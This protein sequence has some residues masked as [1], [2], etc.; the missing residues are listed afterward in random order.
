MADDT[1]G[2]DKDAA[3]EAPK[4]SIATVGEHVSDV[5]VTIGPKFLLLFSEQL[6]SSPNKAFEELVS[7][8]WD[9]G[10][11]A[12]YIGMAEDL[13]A[14]DAAVWV[15]DNGESMDEAGI[16]LLWKVA[17]STKPSRVVKRPQIGKFGIGKLSTYLL[18]HQLTY[19]CKASDGVI[20]AVTLD[21]R[22]I[23]K[24]GEGLHIDELPLEVRAIT[25]DE[26][27]DL[28]ADV[29]GAD[30]ILSILRRGVPHEKADDADEFG[31]G[32]GETQTADPPTGTWTLVVLTDLKDAGRAMETGR[33]RRMLRT[34]LP[35]GGAIS[36]NYC[37]EVLPSTKLDVP[38]MTEW[39]LGPGLGVEVVERTHVDGDSKFLAVTEHA[40][41]YPHLTVE[42]IEG[43]I[44]GT[45]RLFTESISGGKSSAVAASNGFFVNIV[46]RVVN[47]SD[48]YFGLSNLNHSA[49]AKLRVAIRADGLNA[50]ISVDRES[51]LDEEPV[52][53]FR[54]LLRAIFNKARVAH[55]A[56][57]NASWPDVGAVLTEAWGTVPLN[58]LRRVLDDRLANGGA[59]PPPFIAQDEATAEAIEQWEPGSSAEL[60]QDITFV[61]GGPDVPLVQYDVVDRK[62]V[63]NRDHPFAREHGGTHEEQVLLRDGAFVDLLT[64]A[65]MLELGMADDTLSQIGNYRDQLLRLVAR[66]RR[67]SAAQLAEMLDAVTSDW[68]ALERAVTESLEYL[69]FV[70]EYI[71]GSGEPEGVA[72]APL[73]PGTRRA[74]RQYKFTYDAKSSKTGRVANGDVRVSGLLRHKKNHEADHVLIVGPD[75][76]RGALAQECETHKMTPM[77]AGDLARLLLLHATDGPIDLE[78]F[79][80]VFACYDPDAVHEFVEELAAE[81]QAKE[82]LSFDDFFEALSNI[83][84]DEPDALTTDVVAHEIRRMNGTKGYPTAVH[85]AQVVTGLGVL[86]P[87]LIRANGHQIFLGAEPAVLRDAAVRLLARVPDR[88]RS[89]RAR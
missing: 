35:L 46:G 43:R 76:E 52:A 82:R 25:E 80:G 60:V 78:R 40:V 10:A 77:R 18:A 28:L 31:P 48:P 66:I 51:V 58:P 26:L 17:Y 36:I 3:E 12:V 15:L 74:R 34:A 79:R 62:V 13:D 72:E 9:A 59:E 6:Y 84:Y 88:Y 21:Y 22:D 27:E 49:W 30:D 89:T 14:P 81:L 44:T 61:D 11:T 63:V 50:A 57:E 1:Q 56:A 4:R 16:G 73:T 23:G 86:V 5:S 53:I 39:T 75:F 55:D 54:A 38:I 2:T 68:K 37:R 47:P 67:R 87:H 70:V 29:Q 33:I 45:A 83:G 42:G 71:S 20:R 7:N 64:Q 65:Y 69:G 8:S 32:D 85:V 19:V 24:K 41:P